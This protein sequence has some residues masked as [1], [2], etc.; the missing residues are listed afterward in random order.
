MTI[1]VN[2]FVGERLTE[3]RTA[4]GILTKSSL[5]DLLDL[6]NNAV[7]LY[8]NCGIEG[9]KS[10]NPRPE[11]VT[12]MANLLKVKESYF[13]MPITGRSFPMFWRSSHTTTKD[14]RAIAK[15]KFA[16]LKIIDSYLKEYLE[17]PELNIPNR[18]DL[19]VPDDIQFIN[20]SEIEAI[21]LR[22]REYWNLGTSPIPNVTTLLENNGIMVSYG[23]LDSDKL[24][25]FSNRSEHDDSLHIFL[26]TDKGVG[27]RS[28]YDAS[29]ELGHLICHSHLTQEEFLG[30]KHSMYEKQAHRFAASFLMP[31]ES[32]EKD[33][34]MTSIEA[35]R[36]LRK[37]WLVSVGAMMHRCEDLGLYGGRDTRRMWIKYKRNWRNIENDDYQFEQPQLFKRSVDLILSEG[38]R[39]KSQILHDLPF[40]QRDIEKLL[41]L[42]AGYLDENFGEK[43]LFP[44]VRDDQKQRELIDGDGG[45]LILHDFR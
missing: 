6:S 9:K 5:A 10:S 30:K 20:D 12:A 29:H 36:T 11:V 41:S 4:R 15:A 42:S 23:E 19:G 13:F 26:G 27:L 28:R 45:E 22:L 14:K 37:R 35:L 24:D 25:A 31:S 40:N 32:F 3:A 17:M 7:S 2:G 44:T 43:I 16:W 18:R 38:L 39:S 34:W 1:G 33:V 8:E 21:S